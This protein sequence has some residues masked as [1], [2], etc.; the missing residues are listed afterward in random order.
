MVRDQHLLLVCVKRLNETFDQLRAD[1]LQR[2]QTT[3]SGGIQLP[4]GT[5]VNGMQANETEPNSDG[6]ANPS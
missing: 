6:L 4:E 1:L 3:R 2:E 5:V